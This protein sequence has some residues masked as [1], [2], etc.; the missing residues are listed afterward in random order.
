MNDECQI[1]I[2]E[3]LCCPDWLARIPKRRIPATGFTNLIHVGELSW[4]ETQPH[5]DLLKADDIPAGTD[6]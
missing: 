3:D 2:L 4:H 5:Y 1:V 6:N